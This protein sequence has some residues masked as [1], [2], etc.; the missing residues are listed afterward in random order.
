MASIDKSPIFST[1]I[2]LFLVGIGFAEVSMTMPMVQV[3]VYLRELGADISQIGLFFTISMIF[4]LLLRIV[5]G[6]LADSIGHLKVIT[7][8]SFVG[9]LAFAAYALAPTWQAALL[10]PALLAVTTAL[11]IPAYYA[12]IAD[13]SREQARGRAYGISQSVRNMAWVIA[14]PIGGLIGQAFGYQWMFAVSSVAFAIASAIFMLLRRSGPGQTIQDQ[15]PAMGSLRTSLA[16]ISTLF[17]AGGLVTWLLIIDGV[18]DIAFK[19]SFD[20]MPVYLSDIAGIS[21]EGIGF[22]DGIFGL[23]MLITI[24]PAGLLVDRT[25]E[26]FA[27]VLGLISVVLS[28][29]VF[30]TATGYWGFAFSWI[31][32][33]IGVGL[34]DPSGN[35]LV[36]KAVPR[37]LRGLTFGIFATSLSFF[38]LPAPWIGSQIWTRI[39]P[40]YPFLI[41]VVFGSL[42]IVPAWLKLKVPTKRKRPD[43]RPEAATL[44]TIG[45]PSSASILSVGL[46]AGV[47]EAIES[48]PPPELQALL[49][50]I[51]ELVA[52]HGGA[53]THVDAASISACFGLS[54]HR[55]PPQV[56]SLLAAHAALAIR[57]Y[58]REHNLE[59]D[60]EGLETLRIGMGI[61]TGEVTAR[62]IGQRRAGLS[63]VAAS[64]SYTV[65]GET[66]DAARLLLQLTASMP[67]ISILISDNTYRFLSAAHHQ[68]TFGR[69]GP[70][71]YPGDAKAKFA[72]EVVSRS[73]PMRPAGLGD[74]GSGESGGPQT[75]SG[76]S[77]P[78]DQ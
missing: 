42:T 5:G 65:L 49:P 27:L 28:R 7:L 35:S 33:G 40:R 72:Y 47:A 3:P 52:Q 31:L 8:G 66:L 4:P 11:T 18:R 67:A 59:R 32:L 70:V 54:P 50:A 17:L 6:W 41:T 71:S 39:G 77:R 21:K 63:G 16:E 55:A 25:S 36:T 26:R 30:A 38:S 75:R 44:P 56:S 9:V 78:G 20:L 76:I 58:L 73:Q 13:R 24:Y 14:P 48:S 34:F 19:L 1:R 57:D 43:T 64:R 37:H 10:G 12:Y 15:A 29:V 22:L 51:S 53:V 69:S 74:I 62:P 45:E 2:R 60:S 23:A 46:H 68:F 61:S